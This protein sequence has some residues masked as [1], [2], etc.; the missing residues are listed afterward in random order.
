MLTTY[1]RTAG[2]RNF[3]AHAVSGAAAR[4]ADNR[5]DFWDIPALSIEGWGRGL[6]DRQ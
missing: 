2:R 4:L 6:T 5:G 1:T 3:R